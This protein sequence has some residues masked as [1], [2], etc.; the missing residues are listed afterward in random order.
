MR[1][2]FIVKIVQ[3]I[4][5]LL[6][7]SGG[8]MIYFVFN[9]CNEGFAN[10]SQL[11]DCSACSGVTTSTDG[12]CGWDGKTGKCRV[13]TTTDTDY[14]IKTQ[15]CPRTT[16]YNTAHTDGIWIDPTFGCPTCPALTVLPANTAISFQKT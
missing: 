9:P 11:G 6:L 4:I 10:C 5:V 8:Y 15:G 16:A 1:R 14:V 12:L 2:E 7:V 3:L 13:P